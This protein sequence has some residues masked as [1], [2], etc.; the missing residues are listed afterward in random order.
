MLRGMYQ[1]LTLMVPE[2]VV[3]RLVDLADR[4]RRDPRQQAVV[5]LERSLRR[6]AQRGAVDRP[7]MPP[8]GAA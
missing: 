6:Q 3:E 4:E 7:L 8:R 5:L 1:R 2:V